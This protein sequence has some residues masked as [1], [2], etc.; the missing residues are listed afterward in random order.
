[1][2][3]SRNEKTPRQTWWLNLSKEEKAQHVA[4]RK[5]LL[6]TRSPE[7]VEIDKE[8]H[9]QRCKKYCRNYKLLC[10]EYKG[11]CCEHCGL[12]DI[13]DVYDFHHRNPAEKD[14]EISKKL[15]RQSTKLDA[16]IMRELDKCLLLCANCHRRIHYYL[17]NQAEEGKAAATPQ[18]ALDDYI[19]KVEAG[20]KLLAQ[21]RRALEETGRCQLESS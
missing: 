14:F 21:A 9:K 16:E 7:Q 15:S 17:R 4:K 11:G 5:A 3:Y 12:E 8:K 6:E 19:A 13:P 1:M 10:L 20:F 18:L 2:D